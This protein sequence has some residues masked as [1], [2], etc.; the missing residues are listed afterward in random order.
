MSE[1]GVVLQLF[2]LSAIALSSVAWHILIKGVGNVDNLWAFFLVTTMV[3]LLTTSVISYFP[4]VTSPFFFTVIVFSN[5]ATL[6]TYSFPR[7]RWAHQGW[8]AVIGVVDTAAGYLFFKYPESKEMSYFFIGGS[9][10]IVNIIVALRKIKYLKA[11]KLS[12]MLS[13]ISF[14]G[15]IGLIIPVSSGLSILFYNASYYVVS[16][17]IIVPITIIL[18]GSITFFNMN[19]STGL[20]F[21][22]FALM[23]TFSLPVSALTKGLLSF[24]AAISGVVDTAHYSLGASIILFIILCIEGSFLSFAATGIEGFI[25]RSRTYYQKFITQYKLKIDDSTTHSELFELFVTSIH[26][27]FSEIRDTKLLIFSDDF[28]DSIEFSGELVP[29]EILEELCSK[30]SFD[31]EPYVSNVSVDLTPEISSIFKRYG[32]DFIIPI[33]YKS[34]LN[35]LVLL[36]GRKI[37]HSAVM[38]VVNLIEMSLNQY[39]KI[40]LFNSVLEAE[41]KLEASRHFQETGKM[42]SFIAHELR[43]PLSSIL[44]NMEVIQDS[45][46]RKKEI[47]DEYLDISLKEVKRLNETVEK[48][49]TYGRNIKLSVSLG[50]FSDFFQELEH[51]FFNDSDRIDFNNLTGN[52]KFNY[53]WDALKSIFINL[54][55]NSLQAIDRSEKDGSVTVTV[56]KTRTKVTIIISDTGPGIPEEHRASVFEPFYTTRKDGNGLGLATCEKIVKLSGGTIK[57]KDTSEKGTTFEIVLP[58]S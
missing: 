21:V 22:N 56:K 31:Q 12:T 53:D 48:M 17:Y 24:R 52:R 16:I 3:F 28:A 51:I 10:F 25:Y 11:H 49:L 8:L 2:L 39:E 44:F 5:L 29:T 54:I 57:L 41:K 34:E 58:V 32:G 55:N 4:F 47:D 42:V 7:S 50:T 45:I 26:S 1:A 30:G 40:A 14:I 20:T 6:Y 19:A 38:C 36:S 15:I 37:S 9:F 13:Y 23:F 33:K 46:N 27:W 18:L 43:S 35:G